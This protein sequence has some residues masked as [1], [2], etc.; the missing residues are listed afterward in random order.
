MEAIPPTE[1]KSRRRTPGNALA[2]AMMACGVL[3]LAAAV[4]FLLASSRPPEASGPARIGAPLG[5]FGL[6][7]LNGKTVKLSDFSGRPV[8][9]NAWATWCPPCQ[10]EMPDL[11]AYYRT[12][13]PQ[14]LVILAVNAGES[15]AKAGAF[16]RQLGLT[17]PVLL[18]SGENLMDTLHIND[19]PT[20]ILVGR[21]GLVKAV[22]IGRMTP[23]MLDAEITPFL[24]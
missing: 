16:V 18:D 11:Q 8:L 5:N 14:G 19:F 9:I 24:D 2:I 12:H 13:S 21:D 17:F 6:S 15:A 10:D 7:D 23:Q 4:Y 22:H 20:T 1:R 3:L